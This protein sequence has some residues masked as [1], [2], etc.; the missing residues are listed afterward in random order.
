MPAVTGDWR[1]LATSDDS[2]AQQSTKETTDGVVPAV[3]HDGR[4][5]ATSD[6]SPLHGLANTTDGGVPAVREVDGSVDP[7]L[8][9]W[10]V[11]VGSP[12]PSSAYATAYDDECWQMTN[13]D[14]PIQIPA[15]L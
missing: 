3:T 6:G 1:R 15:N 4:R 14:S 12:L 11:C 13:D 7:R 8:L 10:V 2:P 5:L 9:C